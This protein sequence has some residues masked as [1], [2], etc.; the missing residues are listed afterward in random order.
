MVNPL[1]KFE[2]TFIDT[3]TKEQSAFPSPVMMIAR[4]IF[5]LLS[6]QIDYRPVRRNCLNSLPFLRHCGEL[7][8][9]CSF[10]LAYLRPCADTPIIVSEPA[11]EY[12]KIFNAHV[13]FG[14]PARLNFLS[15]TKAREA[16]LARYFIQ[17]PAGIR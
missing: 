12:G 13:L 4:Q 7:E 17:L 6:A 9:C 16:A 15:V 8:H 2:A 10:L 1:M 14:S 5:F 11:N 3:M